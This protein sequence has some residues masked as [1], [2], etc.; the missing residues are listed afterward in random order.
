MPMSESHKPVRI[1]FVCDGDPAASE[2]AFSG[3]AKKM[4]ESLVSRGHSVVSVNSELTGLRRAKVAAMTVSLDRTRWRSRFR[5]GNDSAV[6]RAVAASDSLGNKPV[7]AILQIGAT[8]DPPA[9]DQIPYA[10]Y[11]DWNMA[12]TAK[13]AIAGGG[14][15]GGLDIKEIEAIG[16]E[17]ARRYRGAS[18]VFTISERLRKSFIEDYDLDPDRVQTAYAGPN[19]DTNLIDETLQQPKQSTVPTVLFIAKEFQRKGAS[20]VAAAFSMLQ[21]AMPDAQLVFAGAE[22]MPLEFR[23]L[24]NVVHLGFLD[25]G[26]A[27]Q[28]KRLLSAYRNADVLV[29][30]SRHDPFPTVIREAMFFG[31]PCVASDIWAMPEMIVDGQTGFMVPVDDAEALSDRILKLLKDESLRTKFGQMARARAESMFSWNAV[32]KVL[33]VGLERCCRQPVGA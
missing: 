11:A 9:C 6:C 21:K 13:D 3:T 16:R 25:K 12:L 24:S 8:Y 29:L 26:N 31:I 23:Q 14:K 4:Y 20:T 5:Y 27:T 33:S 7:D 17:H 28:L 30:P 32:G 15:S 1:G 22:V 19:F 2:T 10:I 18:A